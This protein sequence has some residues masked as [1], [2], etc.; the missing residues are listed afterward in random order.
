MITKFISEVSTRFNPFTATAKTA[1][2]FLAILPPNARKN[3]KV[4]VQLLPRTSPDPARSQVQ[5]VVSLPIGQREGIN[6][7]DAFA[8]EDGKQMDFDL[9]KLKIRDITEDVNR[10]SRV[11]G[12]QEELAG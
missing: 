6:L 1:R 9:D 3:M 2:S 10:H 7:A 8:T 5:Y 4:N 11:L 12:R